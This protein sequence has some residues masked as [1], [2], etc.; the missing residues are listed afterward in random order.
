MKLPSAISG[1]TLYVCFDSSYHGFMIEAD[2]SCLRILLGWVSFAWIRLDVE[3]LM[4]V[5][6][7]LV[8][9]VKRLRGELDERT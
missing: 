1:H 4:D 9:E 8:A 6:A 2:D 3:K 7:D 5:T